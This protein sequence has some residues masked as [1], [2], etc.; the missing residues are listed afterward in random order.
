MLCASFNELRSNL[1]KRGGR[2]RAPRSFTNFEDFVSQC[3]MV[4]VEY[5]EPPFTLSNRQMGSA[6]IK[7]RLDCAMSNLD[8]RG[9]FAK[10]QVFKLEPMGSDHSPLVIFFDNVDGF[11]PKS[12]KFELMWLE[13]EKHE[14]MMLF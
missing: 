7:D 10:A 9:N 3:E 6:H 8:W 11:A 13:H 4:Y 12:F 2:I 1:E 14:K 5:K